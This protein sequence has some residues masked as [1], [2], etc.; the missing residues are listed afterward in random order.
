MRELSSARIACDCEWACS[1]CSASSGRA[2]KVR[3]HF[4]PFH[5]P[6]ESTHRCTSS[7]GTT[8]IWPLS[9]ARDRQAR[10]A[11][12]SRDTS[13]R[14]HPSPLR[15]A[16]AHQLERLGVHLSP[17]EASI[18]T[19][20]PACSR[21]SRLLHL[22]TTLLPLAFFPLLLAPTPL[23]RRYCCYSG[24]PSFDNLG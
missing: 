13:S 17:N 19:S 10:L 7:V 18:M 21:R 22:S 12:I 16:Q 1:P 5:P 4:V 20:T 3:P 8:R 23:K 6:A 15:R 9:K 2:K 24:T 11:V 14:T